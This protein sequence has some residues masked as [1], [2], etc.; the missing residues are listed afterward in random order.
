MSA[1]RIQFPIARKDLQRKIDFEE[2][3]EMRRRN[4]FS[5]APEF[6]GMRRNWVL[7]VAGV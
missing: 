6:A 5:A 3:E 2:P 7:M 1:C 4:P